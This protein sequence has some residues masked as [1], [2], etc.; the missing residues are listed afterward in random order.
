MR[1]NLKDIISVLKLVFD[2]YEQLN[3]DFIE[4]DKD[5]YWDIPFDELYNPYKQPENLTLGQL[6]FEIE[7]L[8]K[9]LQGNST[10]VA[11]DLK[12]IANILKAISED[13]Q[14]KGLF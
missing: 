7:E 5:Y 11:Y 4:T 8:Q 13:S 14:S 12:L 1:I 10:I 2:K 3:I 9:L 6:S